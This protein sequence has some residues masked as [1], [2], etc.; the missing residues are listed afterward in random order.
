MIIENV[1]LVNFMTHST[2]DEQFT[3]GV[4][5]IV[6][7]NGSGKSSILKAIGLSLFD[8]KTANLSKMV[9]IGEDFGTIEITF[10]HQG[11]S[12]ILKRTIGKKTSI[13]LES[14]D[15]IILSKNSDVYLLLSNILRVKIPIIFDHIYISSSSLHFPFN[16]EGS[17]RKIFLNQTFDLEKF[18]K[19][20]NELRDPIRELRE[21]IISLEESIRSEEKTIRDLTRDKDNLA[22]YTAELTSTLGKLK[23]QDR[24]LALVN[25]EALLKRKKNSLE[26]SIEQ[27]I[28]ALD[29]LL[30]Y[31]IK[32]SDQ[33]CPTCN[34]VL[35]DDLVLEMLEYNKKLIEKNKKETEKLRLELS[36]INN[37][38]NNIDIPENFTQDPQLSM[39]ATILK[40]SVDRASRDLT[41]LEIR[42]NEL[43]N[44]KEALQQINRK[45]NKLG[46]IKDKLSEVVPILSRSI[47]NQISF[48]ASELASNIFGHNVTVSLD[49]NYDL[50][51]HQSD[52]SLSFDQLSDGE[53]V[54]I[55][56]SLKIAIANY[57]ANDTNL[58][59]LDE[60]TINLDNNSRMNFAQML[61]TFDSQVI[62][63]SHDETFDQYTDNT[64]YL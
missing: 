19:V 32:V 36:T 26:G 12:F 9:K 15:G 49:E 17:R 16:I 24:I 37:Q 31:S 43:L 60:P 53:R 40:T 41:N 35:P 57:L 13:R 2:F 56:L 20:R 23:Y 48:A 47:T 6:G 3:P 46:F 1:K 30:N 14:S 45:Y 52:L 55:S 63:I 7:R 10:S 38:I 62:V 58:L 8:N 11:R 44:T 29:S 50:T 18:D 39:R 22:L 27:S 21:K 61:R 59:I 28:Q 64:I 34:Q 54:A 4:N 5:A 51:I 25:E 33:H 42:Q